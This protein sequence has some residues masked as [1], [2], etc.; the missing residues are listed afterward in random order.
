MFVRIATLL[1]CFCHTLLDFVY[2]PLC[3]SCKKM[4]ENGTEHVC[5]ECWNSIRRVTHDLPLFLETQS[6]LTATGAVDE[7]VSL[8]VFEKE[9][10]FQTIVHHL[11]YGGVDALGLELG[12]RLGRVMTERGI[13]AD[14]IVPVPLHKRKRRERGYNQAEL[15]GRGISE[16]TGIPVRTDIV[17]RKRYTQT[18]TALSLQERQRNMESAFGIVPEKRKEAEGRRIVVVDDVVT[19]G[20]TVIACSQVL[21]DAGVATVLAASSAL[22]E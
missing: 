12:R 7:L 17:R 21:K 9:G 13:S 18:Q 6:K 1:R 16:V 3:L 22:A 11:K 5:A 14:A 19:T 10:V 4:M 15:I 8:F 2:P 20:S